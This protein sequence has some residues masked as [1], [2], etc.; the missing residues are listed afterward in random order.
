MGSV[1]Q[2]IKSKQNHNVANF[3]TMLRIVGTF[4][5]LF[6]K[7]LSTAFF[8]IYTLTGI[9]DVLDGFIARITHT[10]SKFGAKL[11]S[12]A[13]MS[14]YA[15]ML[16][17]IL[18]VLKSKISMQLQLAVVI[19]LIVRICSYVLAAVKYRQFASLHTILNK[20]CGFGVFCVPYASILPFAVTIYWVVCGIAALAAAEELVIHWK[21]GGVK[22]GL[23]R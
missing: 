9:T 22:S 23:L 17:K 3:I 7:P 18:P 8:T 14:F 5:L 2:Q 11:D 4:I 1:C 20:L 10:A 19:I 6:I 16:I 13:D 15:V 12:V 21:R